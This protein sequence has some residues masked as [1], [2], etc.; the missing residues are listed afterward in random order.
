MFLFGI[1]VFVFAET[2]RRIGK[3]EMRSLISR[4]DQAVENWGNTVSEPLGSKLEETEEKD[5]RHIS[6]ISSECPHFSTTA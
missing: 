1:P 2:C 4:K 6:I 5:A 3:D